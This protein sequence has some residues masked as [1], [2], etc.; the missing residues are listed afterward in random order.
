MKKNYYLMDNVGSAKYTVSAHDGESKHKDGS[1]FYDI[2]IFKN[3]KKRDG[4]IKELRKNEY[5]E[6]GAVSSNYLTTPV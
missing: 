1:P 4:Y 3:K 6:R 5:I 2:K